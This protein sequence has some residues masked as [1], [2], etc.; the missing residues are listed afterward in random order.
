[1][2]REQGAQIWGVDE[3]GSGNNA[4]IPVTH[5][6]EYQIKT[7]QYAECRALYLPQGSIPIAGQQQLSMVFTDAAGAWSTYLE[8]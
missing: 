8:S 3:T 7:G 5:T 4:L 2:L 6:L 1:M